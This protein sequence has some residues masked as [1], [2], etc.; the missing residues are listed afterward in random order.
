[1]QIKDVLDAF[2]R[3]AFHAKCP[4]GKGCPYNRFTDCRGRLKADVEKI[5]SGSNAQYWQN[6]A[7]MLE[8][9]CA[10][11]ENKLKWFAKT[12]ISVI[13]EKSI[14]AYEKDKG[15]RAG[16]VVLNRP[17]WRQLKAEVSPYRTHP[18]VDNPNTPDGYACFQRVRIYLIDDGQKT[19]RVYVTDGLETYS[20]GA[21]NAENND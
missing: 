8:T 9:R 12:S 21:T 19:P 20:F 14:D 16:G 10:Q 11:L 18:I 3:C 2:K 6:R 7:T 5:V 1:M 4:G 13:I 17:A 15:H